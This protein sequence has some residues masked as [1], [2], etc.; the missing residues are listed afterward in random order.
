MKGLNRASEVYMECEVGAPH[1][2]VLHFLNY[3]G[4]LTQRWRLMTFLKYYIEFTLYQDGTHAQKLY[5]P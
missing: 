3:K 1:A 4:G 5:T 2:L